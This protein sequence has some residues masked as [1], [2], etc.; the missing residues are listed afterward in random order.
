L[1][2]DTVYVGL[3]LYIDFRGLF[4]Q[5]WPPSTDFIY[6]RSPLFVDLRGL[7]TRL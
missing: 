5:L 7:F 3:P 1:S 6:V 2:V 4:T